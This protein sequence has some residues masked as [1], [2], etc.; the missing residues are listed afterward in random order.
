M[1]DS[2]AP[3]DVIY[4]DFKKAFD[5]VPHQRLLGKLKA[6]DITGVETNFFIWTK[7]DSGKWKAVIMDRY[8]EQNTPRS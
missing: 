3:K 1:L 6:Y 8:P 2:G 5:I 4:L 7:A